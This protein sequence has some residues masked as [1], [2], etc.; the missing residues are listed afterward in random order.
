[1]LRASLASFCSVVI[2]LQIKE[3]SISE[4]KS[5][6]LILTLEPTF[7]VICL[8]AQKRTQNFRVTYQIKDLVDHENHIF[9]YIW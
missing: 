8:V 6:V 1:M 7:V 5:F 9:P 3:Q 4:V 2:S